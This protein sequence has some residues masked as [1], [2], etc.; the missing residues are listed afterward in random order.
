MHVVAGGSAPEGVGQSGEP[1]RFP[2]GA[3]DVYLC[4]K[5]ALQYLEGKADTSIAFAM[6]NSAG[7]LHLCVRDLVQSALYSLPSR[8]TMLYHSEYYLSDDKPGMDAIRRSLRRV[9]FLGTPT[10]FGSILAERRSVFEYYYG[11]IEAAHRLDPTSML[12]ALADDQIRCLP[13]T[14]DLVSQNDP[15]EILVANKS[16]A[17]LATDRGAAY[18]TQFTATTPQGFVHNHIR[19]ACLLR[20]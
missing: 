4:I 16:F 12:G 7:G 14:L 1:A 15:D 10:G 3:E 6:G 2:S 17:K 5:W 8:A 20:S 11:S 9:V 18:E 13:P 19:C